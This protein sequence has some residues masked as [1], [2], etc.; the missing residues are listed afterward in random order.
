MWGKERNKVFL[1]IKHLESNLQSKTLC[2]VA[3]KQSFIHQLTKCVSI[4]IE[5][6]I[7][8]TISCNAMIVLVCNEIGYTDFT[9]QSDSPCFVLNKKKTVAVRFSVFR[10]RFCNEW[11]IS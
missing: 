5:I 9:R 6:K 8:D 3:N 7:A 10:S 2:K 11:P 1:R 4:Y